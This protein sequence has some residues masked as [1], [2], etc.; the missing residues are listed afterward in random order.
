MWFSRR[1]RA[2][3]RRGCDGLGAAVT[4]IPGWP[5]AAARL[6]VPS[7]VF[8]AGLPAPEAVPAPISEPDTVMHSIAALIASGE[9]WT[10]PGPTVGRA[11]VGTTPAPAQPVVLEVP[12]ALAVP[13]VQLGFRDGTTA[14]LDPDSDQALALEE[15][16]VLLNL[17]D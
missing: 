5:I 8:V 6:S 1:S 4:A 2:A 3:R 12:A 10:D 13:R 9:A 14:A 15:L 16:A 17:R 7:V 11:V